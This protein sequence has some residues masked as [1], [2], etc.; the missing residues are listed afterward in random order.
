[1]IITCLYCKKQQKKKYKSKYCNR[2]CYEKGKIKYPLLP[3]ICYQCGK[4][5]TP[6][7]WGGWRKRKLCSRNC[8]YKAETGK[9]VNITQEWRDNMSRGGKGRKLSK[10]HKRKIALAHKG[11]RKKWMDGEKNPNWRQGIT[12]INAKIRSSHAHYL[13]RKAVLE[14]DKKT[15]VKCQ[16]KEKVGVDHIKPFSIFPELRFDISN[17]QA[18]C[19]SCHKIKTKEDVI[20]IRKAYYN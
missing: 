3:L 9:K 11:M 12:K 2:Q 17:G 19:E 7:R 1:M 4:K 13:W 20:K 6:R 16:S 5:F 15:C 14:R 8:V 10:L 18:L